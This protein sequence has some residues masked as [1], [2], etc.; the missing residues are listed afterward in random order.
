M[1]FLRRLGLAALALAVLAGPAAADNYTVKD[2][3]G[4]TQTFCSFTVLGVHYGCQV[5]HGLNAGTPTALNVDASGNPTVN[6]GGSWSVGI[7]GALPSGANVIGGVTQSGLWSVG[8][9]GTPTVNLGSVGGIA[10]AANQAAVQAAAGS[11]SASALGVQGVT[12]GKALATDAS[13]VQGTFGSAIANRAVLY[14]SSGSALSWTDPVDVAQSG[15]WTVQ[16]GNTANTTP[17]LVTPTPSSASGAGVAV[18]SSTAA[19]ACHVLKASAGNLYGVSGYIGAAGF[20]MVFDATSAPSDGAVTPKA[21]AYAPQAGS[22]SI[23]YGAVPAAFSTGVTVCA[24]STGP[25]TKTAYSTNT[26]FS[27]RVK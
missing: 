1:R 21:W 7:T 2:S 20:L 12:G 13:Q 18:V 17:W 9:T 6:Q 25:L 27:G 8:I 26:V 11:N 4:A 14:D 10:T 15:T 24:S 23:D 19:E 16:P 22:W 5:L 3:T